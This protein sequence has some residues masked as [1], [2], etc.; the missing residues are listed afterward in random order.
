[1]IERYDGDFQILINEIAVQKLISLFAH[2][3][4]LQKCLSVY[5]AVGEG[6]IVSEV[7]AHSVRRWSQ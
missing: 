3:F 1:M 4:S 5:V 6:S 7:E 2:V